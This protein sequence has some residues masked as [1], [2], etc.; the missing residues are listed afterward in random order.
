MSLKSAK[1]SSLADKLAEEK[2]VVAILEEEVATEEE[3]LKEVKKV[4]KV[5]K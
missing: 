2:E 4:T 3:K 1:M 5:K